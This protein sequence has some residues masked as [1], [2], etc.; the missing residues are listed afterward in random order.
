MSLRGARMARPNGSSGL[1]GDTPQ[2]NYAQKL[3]R[4][5]LFAEPELRAAIA[6][7]AI[8]PDARILDAGCGSGEALEWLAG[9]DGT[10][11]LVVGMDLA[12]AHTGTARHITASPIAVVQADLLSPP[13]AAASFDLIWSVNT[14]NHL[15]DPIAGL[16]RLASLL[17]S[18]GRIACGQSSLLPDMYFAWDSRLERL[19]NEAVRSY[20][21]KRYGLEERDLAGVRGVVGL[22]RA[23]RL[24]ELA[25]RTFVIER[26][27]PLRA[28]DEAYLLET[29]F[30]DSWGERLRPYLSHP[31]FE[32]LTHLCDPNDQ[33]FALK[34]PD[35]H[36]LQ[37]LTLVVGSV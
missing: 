30:R 26:V 34:R 19:T 21:R 1:L 3:H 13:F 14:I 31:D 27:A 5:N 6:S 12:A 4:F 18:G 10:Q 22:M 17:R 15:R 2:R 20:Y 29:I 25:V 24:R 8:A 35:F 11:R 23:A 9:N 16:E 7:L 36:F 37:T 33:R 32:E 28:A